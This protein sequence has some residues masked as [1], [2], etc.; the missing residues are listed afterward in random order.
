MDAKRGTPDFNQLL[1]GYAAGT[2][3][4]AELQ[5]FCDRLPEHEQAAAAKILADLQSGRYDGQTD[6]AQRNK[7]FATLMLAGRKNTRT[8]RLMWRT[9]AA[10]AILVAVFAGGWFF[11]KTP[12]APAPNDASITA[13][14]SMI[15]PGGKKA[16]LTLSDGA[17]VQLDSADNGMLAQQGAAAVSKL[18]NGMLAYRVTGEPNDEM[19]YNKISTPK[20]G[21]YAVMLPDGSRAYLNAASSIRFPTVFKGTRTVE[22][23]GEVYFEVARNPAV[24]FEVEARGTTV[25]V[26]GTHFN[27]H[28]YE[29]EAATSVTLLEG[30][31]SVANGCENITLQPGQQ[32]IAGAGL[33]KAEGVVDLDEVMAWKNGLFHFEN[34]ALPD[35]MRQ[36]SRWYDVDITYRGNTVNR[37]F[38]GVVSRNSSIAE[39]LQFM[40]LAGVRFEITGRN[41]TVIQ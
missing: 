23:T 9:A 1:E 28:A 32:A 12:V 40:Q 29:D 14:S 22:I 34:L 41:I 26:H 18:K 21:V 39:V 25:M 3:S 13:V 37:R 20:G 38:S 5:A 19:R 11:L 6:A 24:Q 7:M 33:R 10:A 15:V 8:F 17:I 31:V 36:I 16:I 30:A 4:E 2:L 35:I 27:I